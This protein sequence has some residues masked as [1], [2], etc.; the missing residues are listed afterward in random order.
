MR[1]RPESKDCL[2]CPI[3]AT[4]FCSEVPDGEVDELWR[5]RQCVVLRKGQAIVS[6]A[7]LARAYYN[8]VFGMVKLSRSTSDGRTQIVGFRGPAEFF[9]IPEATS[10][11]LQIAALVDVKL[12]RFSRSQLRHLMQKYPSLQSRL[13]DD[14]FGRIEALESHALVLGQRTAREKIASFLLQRRDGKNIGSPDRQRVAIPMTRVEI[15]EFLGL[16]PETVS[17]TLASFKREG[18]VSFGQAKSVWLLDMRSLEH[19][20]TGAG[21]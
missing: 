1:D 10:D 17:R 12:C 4:N 20:A 11:T 18:L 5:S 7:A 13:L 9:S 8:V 15:A 6:D 19:V 21:V 16:A 14:S 3:R 2:S